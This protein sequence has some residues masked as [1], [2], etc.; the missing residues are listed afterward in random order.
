M[1][2]GRRIVD[3]AKD[4]KRGRK[5]RG[6]RFGASPIIL[7]SSATT[8]RLFL[9]P[10]LRGGDVQI[11]LMADQ[12]GKLCPTG[13][14]I[15]FP[16]WCVFRCQPP[17]PPPFALVSRPCLG[18]TKKRRRRPRSLIDGIVGA[19]VDRAILERYVSF[20]GENFVYRFVHS[21]TLLLDT[22]EEVVRYYGKEK[23]RN[24][25]RETE[26]ES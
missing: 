5:G 24:L 18:S 8:H 17:P 13:T 10:W 11:A 14:L 1:R 4:R 21:P 7:Q 20:E 16:S 6:K 23:R 9:P 26:R 25:D 12:R 3:G 22:R 2:D 19:N 15:F